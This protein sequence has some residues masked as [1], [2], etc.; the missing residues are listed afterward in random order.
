[1][2]D[3]KDKWKVIVFTMLVTLAGTTAYALIT[4][5]GATIKNAATKNDLKCVEDELKAEDSKIRYILKE[6]LNKDDFTFYII[7]QQKQIDIMDQRIYDMW[8]LRETK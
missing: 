2:A 5:T 8:K 6:K 7:Q 4:N 1:M 3:L